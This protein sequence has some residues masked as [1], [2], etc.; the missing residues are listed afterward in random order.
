MKQV[1]HLMYP[2]E[3]ACENKILDLTRQEDV[4]VRSRKDQTIFEII[5]RSQ[6]ERLKRTCLPLPMEG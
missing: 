4:N 2:E 5:A 6:C 3:L 1:H